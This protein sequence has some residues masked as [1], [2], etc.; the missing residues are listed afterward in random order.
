MVQ[1]GLQSGGGVAWDL[2]GAGGL[3]CITVFR[4]FALLSA[5]QFVLHMTQ[6]A[7]GETVEF[8]EV[9]RTQEQRLHRNKGTEETYSEK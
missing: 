6:R 1:C 5:A 8:I 3:I 4:N 2:M 9:P 7:S